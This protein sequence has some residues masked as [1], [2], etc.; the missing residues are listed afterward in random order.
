MIPV[1]LLIVETSQNEMKEAQPTLLPL[2]QLAHELGKQ[3]DIKPVLCCKPHLL[4]QISGS[5]SQQKMGP[6][7]E[8][9]VLVRYLTRM[10]SCKEKSAVF[11]KHESQVW[12]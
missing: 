4:E 11:T 5:V 6:D 7:A 12:N 9:L 1:V 2:L 10:K 3:K 8:L